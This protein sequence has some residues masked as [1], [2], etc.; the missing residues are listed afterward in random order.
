MTPESDI[1][2]QR[3]ERPFISNILAERYPSTPMVVVFSPENKIICERG[4]WIAVMKAQQDLGLNIPEAAIQ[5]YDNVKDNVDLESIRNK[6]LILKHDEKAKLDVFNELAGYEYAHLGMTSRDQSD[7]IEQM[8]IKQGLLIIRDHSV[9]ALARLARLSLEHSIQVYAERT[10]NVPAQPSLLGKIFSNFGEEA[11]VGFDRLETLLGKYPLRGIKGAVGTQT[12]QL[13]L[14]KDQDKVDA[15]EQKVAE[16]LGFKNVL[17]SVGQVYPRSFDFEVVSTLYQLACGPASLAQTMR[18]MAGNE[19][20]TEG[21]KKGQV[22][23]TAMPHKMN[24]RS[25]ERIKALKEVLAGHV[26]MAANVSGEQWYAGDVSDSATRRVFLADSFFATDGILETTLTV[27]DDC[28]FYPAVIQRELDRYLPFLTT[29]RLL[30]AA[31]EQSVGR[32]TAHKII[33]DHA[34]AV[35]LSMREQGIG[36]NELLEHLAKDTRLG[37]SKKQLEG[38]IANPIEFVGSAQRQISNFTNK[39]EQIVNKYPQAAAYVPEP[40]L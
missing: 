30:M 17:G 38:A 28:G 9:A 27:L 12:D 10:H 3:F 32:E 35:A 26:I 7:N 33:K 15:L 24:S 39:V 31:V 21:F 29:T 4:L 22:G 25:C 6:E 16:Y 20:F 5:A 14:L 8:Q 36:K 11:L 37:L 34:V 23:S 40:I 18:L 2:K 13:Q 1:A 19:Q